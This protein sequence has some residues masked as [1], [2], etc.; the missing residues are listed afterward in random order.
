MQKKIPLQGPEWLYRIQVKWILRDVIFNIILSL[1]TP[2]VLGTSDE[3]PHETYSNRSFAVLAGFPFVEWSLGKKGEG[4]LRVCLPGDE[5]L[6]LYDRSQDGRPVCLRNSG[7]AAY[8]ASA[9]R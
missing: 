7:R 3:I 9:A 8:E 6:F 4:R 2:E 1:S 5:V